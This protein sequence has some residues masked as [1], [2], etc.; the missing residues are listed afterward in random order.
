M[1]AR[2]PKPTSAQGH[3]GRLRERFL[4]AGLEGFQDY[5]VVELL[6]TLGT[7]RRDCKPA[8]K[9]LMARFETLPAVFQAS[10]REL[11]EVDGVGPRNLLGLKLIK[12]VADRYL[13]ARVLQTVPLHN[14]RELFDYLYHTLRDRKREEFRV[15]FLDAKNRLLAARTLF[16]GTLTASGVYPREVVRAA[17]D[18]HAAALLFAHN[19]PSGDPE[20]SPED[21]AITRRLALVC[22]AMGIPVHDHII[23][24]ANRYF[25]FADQGL[26]R[27]LEEEQRGLL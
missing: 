3:R 5:E 13:A 4:A 14:S 8:A 26:M 7:P 23:I 25:S 12:A 17:L 1:P 2:T 20:P 15:L 11:C 19:H 10:P 22:R 9:A 27:R 24:G 21:V 18:H 16:E 6:L